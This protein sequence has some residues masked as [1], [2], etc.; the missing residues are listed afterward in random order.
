MVGSASPLVCVPSCYSSL[1]RY[2]CLLFV[3]TLCGGLGH[4]PLWSIVSLSV[5]PVSL[6]LFALRVGGGAGVFLPF[7][8]CAS[9]LSF[10]IF[11][12]VCLSV[13]VVGTRP[14]SPQIW[15]RRK[16][17]ARKHRPRG[18]KTQP[19]QRQQRERVNHRKKEMVHEPVFSKELMNVSGVGKELVKDFGVGKEVVKDSALARK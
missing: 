11:M 8:L 14:S 3:L 19:P 6:C 4:P 12:S 7:G 18:R 17:T 2:T 16:S 10:S 15:L 13:L 1:Y 5:L 9:L